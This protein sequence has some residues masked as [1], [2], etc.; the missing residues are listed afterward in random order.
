MGSWLENLLV[1]SLAAAEASW[2]PLALPEQDGLV[3]S[4]R[5]EAV[6]REHTELMA[7][8][9]SSFVASGTLAGKVRHPGRQVASS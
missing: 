8:L 2:E 7:Q 4:F 5:K 3:H 1:C 9:A 6:F